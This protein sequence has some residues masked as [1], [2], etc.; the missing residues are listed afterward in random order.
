MFKAVK[1]DIISENNQSIKSSLDF[2]FEYL[3][4]K[5]NKDHVDLSLIHI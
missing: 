1:K 5:L 2:D 4:K 3:E